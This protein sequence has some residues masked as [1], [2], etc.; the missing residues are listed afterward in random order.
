MRGR[1]L[2]VMALGC[3]LAIMYGVFIVSVEADAA[4]LPQPMVVTTDLDAVLA[5]GAP[6][7][8]EPPDPGRV[9]MRHPSEYRTQLVANHEDLSFEEPEPI[10]IT[11]VEGFK[12]ATLCSVTVGAALI[13]GCRQLRQ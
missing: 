7:A 6:E 1:R 10:P 9:T 12:I 8:S 3:C 5:A 4:E 11:D 2:L 13:G